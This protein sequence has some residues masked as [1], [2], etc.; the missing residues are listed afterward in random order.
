MS[1]EQGGDKPREAY[2]KVP[3]ETMHKWRLAL[4]QGDASPRWEIE[5]M[6]AFPPHTSPSSVATNEIEAAHAMLD[7]HDIS[8]V[9]SMDAGKTWPAYTLAER[10][11]I[12]CGALKLTEQEDEER[13]ASQSATAALDMPRIEV[14][15]ALTAWA[16]GKPDLLAHRP[17]RR[18]GAPDNISY[19]L[20]ELRTLLRAAIQKPEAYVPGGSHGKV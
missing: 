14:A 2:F 4:S 16:D 5:Q 13:E 7:E 20:R 3:L 1:H 19:Q 15:L 18:M 10:I 17:N 6:L 8:R 9:Y 12:V 11:R